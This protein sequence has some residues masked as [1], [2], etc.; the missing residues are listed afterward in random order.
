M[1]HLKVLV[2]GA[3]GF[4]G[5]NL[6]A[7]LAVRPETTVL[8]FDQQHSPEDLAAMLAEADVV[9]HLAGVNRPR[10]D[11]EFTT[12]NV[13]LTEAVCAGLVAAGR[14]TPI[15]LAS[16][17][18]A[19]LDNPYGASKRQAEAV[20]AAYARATGARCTIFRLQN[21]FGK[22]CR[23]NYNSVVATFCHNISRDE[24][25]TI[26]HPDRELELV[27]VDD[28]AAGIGEWGLGA[29]ERGLGIG[30]RGTG[31]GDWGLGTGDWGAGTGE[32]GVV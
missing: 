27:H 15:V 17:V 13:G 25:I 30:E 14:A 20:V 19:A 3:E 4:I 16:S 8:C 28:V 22:W 2:T 5:K 26:S 23:P 11:A 18:Q 12:G 6:R 1:G 9:V 32:P 21:V 10:S 24:P 29:G 31:N 7:A